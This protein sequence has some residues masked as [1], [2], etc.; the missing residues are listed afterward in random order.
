MEAI[1]AELLTNFCKNHQFYI[2][3]IGTFHH[4]FLRNLYL[5]ERYRTKIREMQYLI[6]I[7]IGR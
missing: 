2:F 5:L 7:K 1:L 6:T 3:I 4:L